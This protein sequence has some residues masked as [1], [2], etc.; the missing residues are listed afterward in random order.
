MT[1]IMQHLR[2]SSCALIKGIAFVCNHQVTQLFIG[3]NYRLQ[4]ECR[5]EVCM[6][7]AL[8]KTSHDSRE[9]EL[10]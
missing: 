1:Y 8:K 7:L 6:D 5:V 4:D 2:S 3:S 9:G 10:T